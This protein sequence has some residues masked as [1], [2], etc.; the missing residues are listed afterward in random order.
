MVLGQ[1]W[2]LMILRNVL[3]TDSSKHDKNV[4]FHAGEHDLYK[5]RRQR[6]NAKVKE[7][8]KGRNL[9]DFHE[10]GAGFQR[11]DANR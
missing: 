6:V 3:R 4:V 5:L 1:E 7:A 11:L 9:R 2:L 8:E 10:N